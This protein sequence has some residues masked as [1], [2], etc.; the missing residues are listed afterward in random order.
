MA[1]AI[2][3]GV[4][5]RVQAPVPSSTVAPDPGIPPSLAL[6]YQQWQASQNPVPRID[7]SQI[8]SERTAIG[9]NYVTTNEPGPDGRMYQVTYDPTTGKIIGQPILAAN[10]SAAPG[11][12]AGGGGAPNI[13]QI[14]YG[15]GGGGAMTAYEQAQVALDKQKLAD[16]E[17]QQ[18][19]D[20]AY[21][22]A[23]ALDTFNKNWQDYQTKNYYG[24]FY[25]PASA[26]P[27]GSPFAYKLP[28]PDF[29]QQYYANNPNAGPDPFQQ[30][31]P[32]SGYSGSGF[33]NPQQ[34]GIQNAGAIP[35]GASVSAPI[36]GAAPAN[37]FPGATT[38]SLGAY[39][40]AAPQTGQNVPLDPN[41]LN[42]ISSHPAANQFVLSLPGAMDFVSKTLGSGATGAPTGTPQPNVAAPTSG[43]ANG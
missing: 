16:A 11:S 14:P 39:N 36:S 33:L 12:P 9:P 34:P 13:P 5:G 31:L 7:Q 17:A 28:E 37:P 25:G 4:G 43:G 1:N 15:A 21:R 2:D 40:P 35:A 41:L 32:F 10:Q 23:Q 3:V 38:G 42:A 30:A 8:Q 22:Q 29:V 20:Q 26:A 19:A 24:S 27:A 18:K 6:Q